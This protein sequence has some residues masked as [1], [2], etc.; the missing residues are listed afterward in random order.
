MDECPVRE[1]RAAA[2]NRV[3]D[4]GNGAFEPQAPMP[5]RR[6]SDPCRGQEGLKVTIRGVFHEG[7]V[8]GVSPE[9]WTVRPNSH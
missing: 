9:Y 7:L 4:G 8:R 5:P 3:V 6:E 2:S 1:S